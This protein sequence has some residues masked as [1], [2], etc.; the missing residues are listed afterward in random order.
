MLSWELGLRGFVLLNHENSLMIEKV[1]ESIAEIINDNSVV[2]NKGY[3]QIIAE[4]F[5]LDGQQINALFESVKCITLKKYGDLL[6]VEYVKEFLNNENLT[7]YQIARKLGYR[8]TQHLSNQFREITGMT[9]ARYRSLKMF[10]K[11][12][13]CGLNEN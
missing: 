9:P 13:Q 2:G 5:H 7:I 10:A 3:T 12:Y 1:K 4:K 11:I 6:K 8:N